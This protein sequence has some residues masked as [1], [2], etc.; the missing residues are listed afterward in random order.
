MKPI[1]TIISLLLGICLVGYTGLSRA[2]TPYTVEIEPN[3]IHI[4]AGYNGARVLVKG[5]IPKD[6]DIV[7]QVTDAPEDVSLLKKGHVGGVLWMNTVTV[8]FSDLPKVCLLYLPKSISV[9]AL[10]RDVALQQLNMGFSALERQTTLMPEEEN[11]AT[12]FQELVKLKTHEELYAQVEN[13]ISYQDKDGTMKSYTCEIQIPSRIKEGTY[14]IKAC[15]VKNKGVLYTDN[16][17]IKIAETGFP[18]LISRL[19][20]QHGTL[21]GVLATVIALIAGLLIGFIFK[22]GSGGH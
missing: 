6:T 2:A 5:E 13:A 19:A 4:G 3:L 7:I 15:I 9:S 20:F 1:T 8:T 18:E 17:Q 21:Y 22:G 14:T 16:R 12:L 11:K 10:D